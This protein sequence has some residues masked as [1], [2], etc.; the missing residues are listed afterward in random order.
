LDLDL[1]GR[2][3]AQLNILM[4]AA[5]FATQIAIVDVE[6]ILISSSRAWATV[7]GHSIYAALASV[8]DGHS[9]F[10]VAVTGRQEADDAVET[11]LQGVR[12]VLTGTFG[13]F[14]QEAADPVASPQRWSEVSVISLTQTNQAAISIGDTTELRRAEQL[15]ASELQD[16]RDE[17]DQLEFLV[18]MDGLTGLKNFRTLNE[19]LLREWE[20][21][22]RYQCDLSVLLLDVDYFKAY[23]DSFGHQA[24]NLALQVLAESLRKTAR[25]TDLVARYGGEEFAILLP[26]TDEAGA[27]AMA[28]RFQGALQAVLWLNR[29]LTVSIGLA[30]WKPS[31][32][33]R[34]SDPL[35][36]LEQADQAMYAAKLS[37]RNNISCFS[38]LAPSDSVTKPD[39]IDGYR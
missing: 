13:N 17:W 5:R 19:H 22:Q 21:T 20:R 11:L 28:R 23:N 35:R 2:R 8:P 26:N 27:M 31:P 12:G 24:G 7:V 34:G 9:L 38:T 1:F 33:G 32:G 16:M 10:T 29:P 30:S 39:E 37:G 36:L 18:T 14:R 15:I 6:G 25:E 3:L 4:E